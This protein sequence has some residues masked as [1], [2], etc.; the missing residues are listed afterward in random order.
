MKL[1]IDENLSVRV[2]HQLA[3]AGLDATHV[4]DVGLANAEDR[5]ILEY[6]LVEEVVIVTADT[7]LRRPGVDLHRR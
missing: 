4:T 6:A 2:A 5:A 7:V 1:L 3:E